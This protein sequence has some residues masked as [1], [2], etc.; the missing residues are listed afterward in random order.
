[1]T[2]SKPRRR[3]LQFR[4]RTIFVLL[5]ILGLWLGVQANRAQRQRRAVDA[6][7]DRGGQVQYD[8]EF[9]EDGHE[10]WLAE[11]PEPPGPKW[12]RTLVGDDYFRTVVDV[13]FRTAT[14]ADMEGLAALTDLIEL[15]LIGAEVTG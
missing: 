10:I 15:D 7:L 4:L 13:T 1:M 14:D 11:P 2:D 8:Y 12:L 9:D 6:I 3:W 5:T